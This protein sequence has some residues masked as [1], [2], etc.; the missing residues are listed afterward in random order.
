MNVSKNIENFIY[1]DN[2]SIERVCQELKERFLK[3]KIYSYFGNVLF[4]INPYQYFTGNENIYNY[5]TYLNTDINNKTAHLFDMCES[6]VNNINKINGQTYIISGESGSGK[7]ETVKNIIKFLNFRTT[8]KKVNLL[9]K[10]DLSGLLLEQFG[11]AKTVRNNNSS[12]FGKYI[13]IFYNN[14]KECIG[15]DISVYLLEKTRIK[16]FRMLDDIETNFHIFNSILNNLNYINELFLNIGFTETQITKIINILKSIPLF[17]NLNI[18]NITI[19]NIGNISELLLLDRNILHKILTE[20]TSSIADEHIKIIYT[21]VEFIEVCNTFAMKLYE[22]L[23]TYIVD[24]INILFK[25]EKNNTLSTIGL[26]DIFGFESIEPN[27]LEQLCINYTNEILQQYLNRKVINDKIDFYNEEGIPIDSNDNYYYND[28]STIELLQNIFF[29]LDEECFVP[30]G[31]DKTLIDKMN[32]QFN[33]N[34]KYHSKRLKKNT[35]FTIEHFAGKIDYQIDGFIKKNTDRLNNDIENIIHNIFYDNC[36]QKNKKNKLKMNSITNQFRNELDY[37]MKRIEN[38]EIYFIKCIKPNEKELS[39]NF[40]DE[41]VK[42]QLEYNGVLKLIDILKKGYPYHFNHTFF[43]EEYHSIFNNIKNL[44][45][46]GKTK[47][48]ITDNIYNNINVMKYELETKSQITISKYFKGFLQKKLFQK[49]KNAIQYISYIIF[50]KKCNINLGINLKVY[51]IQKAFLDYILRKNKKQLDYQNCIAGSLQRY[52]IQT[53]YNLQT[54]SRLLL[55]SKIKSKVIYHKYRNYKNAYLSISKWW[56]CYLNRKNN[57]IKKVD[58]LESV[59]SIRDR[60]ICELEIK[61]MELETKLSRSLHIDKSILYDRD[62]TISQL[63]LD[64]ELFRNTI[65][66]KLKEKVSLIDEIDSL[67]IENKI[68]IRQ[69]ANMRTYNNSNWFQRLFN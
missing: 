19:D 64:V 41:I 68:L 9:E 12:R 58:Y 46:K 4:S 33:D 40:N 39:M 54:Q 38:H 34:I 2:Y 18:D 43:E 37:F 1:L 66:D 11:N 36:K 59:L 69:I 17:F 44:L 31:T 15:M 28:K 30:K 57:Y 65:N 25:V 7:T 16:S 21:N 32:I 6:V 26:L 13:E 35:E 63:K 53:K 61:I 10:I 5:T 47:Y 62:T 56:R 48:F 24:N 29:K 42:K 23:F 20:K 55:I 3:R 51:K 14:Q 60:K 45:I 22:K 50:I 8:N 49:K 52:H 27:S 67:K